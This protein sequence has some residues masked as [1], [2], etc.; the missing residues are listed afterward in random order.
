VTL[1]GHDEKDNSVNPE[2]FRGLIN[3]A[4]KLETK[5]KVFYC[6]SNMHKFCKLIELL[7]LILENSPVKLQ[8]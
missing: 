8:N 1:H 7:K 6:K 2:V 3:F 4:S 5:L